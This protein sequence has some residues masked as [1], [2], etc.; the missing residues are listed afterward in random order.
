MSIVIRVEEEEMEVVEVE[1]VEARGRVEQNC[2]GRKCRGVCVSSFPP[3]V[4]KEKTVE[5]AEEEETRG[6]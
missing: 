2:E 4:W 1:V 3:V 6:K 5:A